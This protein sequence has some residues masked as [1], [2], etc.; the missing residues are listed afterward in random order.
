MS[1]DRVTIHDARK[2]GYCV[3][4][5]RRRLEELGIDFKDFVQNGGDLAYYEELGKTD[6]QIRRSCEVARQR[7]EKGE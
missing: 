5:A 3:K 4:G 1:T 6:N 2:A 7:I